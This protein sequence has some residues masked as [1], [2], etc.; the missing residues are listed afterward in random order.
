MFE[1]KAIIYT[2][3]KPVTFGDYTFFARP[4][5]LKNDE[6]VC[7]HIR[8]VMA[9]DDCGVC[10]EIIGKRW[11]VMR[12]G[13][14]T[15]VGMATRSL[16]RKDELGRVVRGYYGFLMPS[17][18]ACLP[19]AELFDELDRRFVIP[20]FEDANITPIDTGFL[21]GG[22]FDDRAQ[23]GAPSLVDGYDFNL[24]RSKIKFHVAEGVQPLL[25]SAVACAMRNERFEIVT[26]LNT[27]D[28]AKRLPV[29]NC[30]CLAEH[31]VR[32]IDLEILKR[33]DSALPHKMPQKEIPIFRDLGSNCKT[34]ALPDDIED[35]QERI[36]IDIPS[37]GRGN[38][39]R[40]LV[41]GSIRNALRFVGWRE[42]RVSSATPSL[43]DAGLDKR[44][45]VLQRRKAARRILELGDKA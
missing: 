4:S 14:N 23:Y 43:S 22:P 27:V 35:R 16:G 11:H 21:S 15:I 12:T 32:T 31:A 29:M 24:D 41:V 17:S 26:G 28:H 37:S 45:D 40:T 25:A 36:V 7:D 34:T 2:R 13:D 6:Y 5:E 20:R 19:S 1:M 42:F 3:P 8:N 44:G 39:F 38:G 30:M 33:P 10:G 18:K 9:E